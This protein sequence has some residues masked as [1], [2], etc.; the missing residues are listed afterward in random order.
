MSPSSG[1]ITPVHDLHT[2]EVAVAVLGGLLVVEFDGA[3]GQHHRDRHVTIG[4]QH[5]DW[6]CL[7]VDGLGLA[8]DG[9]GLVVEILQ[10]RYQFVGRRSAGGNGAEFRW[11]P[12]GQLRTERVELQ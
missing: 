12:H 5:R 2:F 9:L 6:L 10:I 3:A 4:L 11:R 1:K 8:V 7:A